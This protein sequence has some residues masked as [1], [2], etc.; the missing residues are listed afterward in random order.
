MIGK[1]QKSTHAKG[2][3]GGWDG[4]WIKEY[5]GD[6]CF[7][8]CSKNTL[9]NFRRFLRRISLGSWVADQALRFELKLMGRGDEL[10][11][12]ERKLYFYIDS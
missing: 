8:V 4:G 6:K 11:L 1:E 3:G 7:F 10:V 5:R 2:G 12:I 9:Y